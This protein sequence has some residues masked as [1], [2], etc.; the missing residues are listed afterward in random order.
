[1]TKFSPL[2][3]TPL[4]KPLLVKFSESGQVTLSRAEAQIQIDFA[5]ISALI[6][7]LK[8]IQRKAKGQS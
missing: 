6:K 7:L 3:S 5:E 4:H 2:K 1:M 8:E